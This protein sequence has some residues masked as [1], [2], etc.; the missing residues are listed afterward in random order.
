[1]CINYLQLHPT[2][3]HNENADLSILLIDFLKFYGQNFDYMN[4]GITI[5]NGGKIVPKRELPCCGVNNGHSQLLCIEHPVSTWENVGNNSYR[6]L[7]AKQAFDD[8]YV[9]LSTAVFA[10]QKNSSSDCTSQSILGR[11]INISKD[12]IEYRKWIQNTFDARTHF[13]TQC[14][15]E[16]T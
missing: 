6:V 12:I 1:M 9:T 8:A 13:A 3:E 14:E 15:L 2:Y 7:E 11:V 16:E 5:R 4:S 10:S